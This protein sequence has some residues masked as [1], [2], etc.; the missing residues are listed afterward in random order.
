MTKTQKFKKQL[1]VLFDD[2]LHTKVWHNAVDW[3]IIGLIL[4]STLEVFLSTFPGVL[5]R[6]GTVLEFVAVATTVFFTIEVSLRIWAASDA[7]PR[8]P[9]WKGR[10][11]YC[12]SFFGLI[13]IFST[14][15][16]YLGFFFPVPVAAFKVLR[17]SRLLRTFR[18]VK[19]YSV[20]KAAVA[21]K[22]RELA[23]SLVFL[24]VITVILSML[25]YIA[26]HDA[27]PDM[28]ENGWNAVV[29]SFAK[30]LGDPGNMADVT[31]ATPWGK[32][33]AALVGVLGICIFA[34]PA[35]LIGSGFIE[36]IEAERHQKELEENTDK[37]HRA[38]ER[39]MDRPTGFQVMPK[40]LSIAEIQARMRMTEGEIF[41]AVDA[42][43]DFRIINVAATI[44]PDKNPQDRLAVEHFQVNTPY[45]CKIDRGSKVTIISVSD[46]VD[47]VNGYFAYYLAKMGGFNFVGREL[48]QTRPYKSY[49]V[50]SEAD[51]PKEQR[52]FMADLNA[53][54]SG[55][56]SWTI[57]FLAAS[58]QNEPELP[59][60]VHFTYGGPKGDPSLDADTLVVHDTHLADKLMTD[61][62]AALKADFDVDSDRQRFHTTVNPKLFVRHLKNATLNS[63]IIRVA[64]SLSA[65]SVHNMAV[66]K[67]IADIIHADIEP[68]H[69]NPAADELTIKGLGIDDYKH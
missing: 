14:F 15:P 44:T 16:F 61:M 3:V 35:G 48:G 59:T 64:W 47:P 60:Q 28:Y 6:W 55:P 43:K 45:G 57:T 66:A 54:T 51:A 22:R 52:Q 26:E 68:D 65:H 25:L 21:S 31:L 8:Y 13:D 41:E 49:Y 38:F 46:I 34:V 32:L 2:N 69:A 50:Y 19:S 18:Y 58:G 63:L 53:L 40:F 27:N 37:L 30:Y 29:W 23:I 4:L 42:N 20:L 1:V 36:A 39:K 12:T 10:L 7:D 24:V 67:K 17:V 62:A 9:G 56:G 33:I 11:R 5:H